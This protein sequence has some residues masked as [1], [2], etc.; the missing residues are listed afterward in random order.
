MKVRLNQ[1]RR[2]GRGP[3]VVVTKAQEVAINLDEGP[4]AKAVAEA[5]K[6]SL[7]AGIR[8]VPTNAAGGKHRRWNRSGHLANNLR[9]EMVGTTAHVRPPDDR[10]NFDGALEQLAEDVKAA[11]EPLTEPRVKEAIGKAIENIVTV[12]KVLL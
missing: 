3:V 1:P 8:A 10:L 5:A 11:R 6:Q 7:E 9:V 4:I 2:S 12:K